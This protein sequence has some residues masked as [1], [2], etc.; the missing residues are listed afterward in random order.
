MG[1]EGRIIACSG[2]AGV[3]LL[4]RVRVCK[5]RVGVCA[6]RKVVAVRMMAF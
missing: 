5:R 2:Y 6:G 1:L 3:E 4:L